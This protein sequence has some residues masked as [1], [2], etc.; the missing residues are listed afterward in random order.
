MISFLRR[1]VVDSWVGRVLAL[2][3]FIAFVTWGVGDVISNLGDDPSVAAS[4]GS[5]KI[6]SRE[7]ATALQA[8]LPQMAQ[9]M[10]APDIK[11]LPPQFRNQMAQQVLQR[12]IGQA[13][14]LEAGAAMGLVVPDSAVREEIFAMPYFKD[15]DG[16][17]DRKLFDSRMAQAGMTEQ[18]LI[19][20]V[21]DDLAGR[22]VLDA[23]LSGAH[24]PDVLVSRTYGFE[25]ETRVLDV[26]HIP[27]ASEPM[28]QDPDDAT[29]RRF[30][31]N[32][33]WLFVSP[34]LRHARVVVLSPDTVASTVSA[35]D[36]EMHRL[37]DAQK[38]RFHL[39]ELRSVQLVTA[40]DET[41]AQA[42]ATVWR[43]GATWAQ[44]QAA[45]KDS[46]AVEFDDAR[47]SSLPSEA[48][49]KLVFSAP[50]DTVQGPVK[51]DTG[52]VV[53]HVVK[54]TPPKDTGFDDAKASL[55]DQI[56]KA[57]APETV[58]ANVKKLQDAIAGGGLDAIPSDLGAAA[59][60][61][62]LD[63]AGMTKDG[64]PAPLPASGAL[65]D[66]VVARIFSQAKGA[67]PVLT[68]ATAPAKQGQP[69]QSLGW[70]AVS[71]DD[72]TVSQ[73]VPFDQAR[74]RVIA[75]WR[76]EAR[77][78]AADEQATGLYLAAQQQGGIAAVAPTG[79]DLKKGVFASRARPP[80]GLP[81][82]LAQTVLRM[83][84]GR[85]VMG[86]DS[87]SYIVVTATAVQH[88][89]PAADSLG[90]GRV[91]DGL[92]DSLTSDLTGVLTRSLGERYKAKIVP[93]GVKAA[94]D[95]AG[96]GDGS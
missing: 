6:S 80:E 96:F 68:E 22:G 28:P 86:E 95:M 15:K 61:G 33:P 66:A 14:V 71:V 31:T 38:E 12:L 93:A 4:V 13:Q 34:E 25:T 87:E 60:A 21:R 82:D 29:L 7:L 77:R 46:A 18:R 32:H 43:G 54:V 30:Y 2:V 23:T 10:G 47:E 59:A 56:V 5:R 41:Q 40:P 57:R 27:F 17:F 9:R 45:A 44:V 81:E 62:T 92:T 84:A 39:P 74:A 63:S 88:P 58:N 20:L 11:N 8:E 75:A 64:E 72:V 19:G 79:A 1:F 67:P 50:A 35:T 55:K 42:I 53:F 48:L 89:D 24:V 37:Y 26:L 78:H 36:E 83:P 90:F 49:Q 70:Y 65:R 52:W 16:K 91:R 94:L 85:S 51:V 3:I 73:P 69:G 76:D